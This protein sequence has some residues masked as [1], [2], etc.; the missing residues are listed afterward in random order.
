VTP[1]L[2]RSMSLIKFAVREAAAFVGHSFAEDDRQVVGR[3]TAFLS[4][5]GVTCDSGQR[6]EPRQISEKVL[7]RILAAELKGDR[8]T[9]RRL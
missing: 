2:L 5:L 7:E 9:S 3:I 6:A 1:D 4:K 8:G